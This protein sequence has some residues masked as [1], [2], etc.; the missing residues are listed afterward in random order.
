LLFGGH[1][2]P[3]LLDTK[4]VQLEAQLEVGMQVLEDA[5]CNWQKSPDRFKPFR[6]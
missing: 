3:A 2:S 6:G 4:L 1:D 5:L